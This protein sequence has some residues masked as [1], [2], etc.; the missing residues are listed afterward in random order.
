VNNGEQTTIPGADPVTRFWTDMM[1]R[2]AATGMSAPPASQ[3]MIEQ[4][5][6]AFFDV[7]GKHVDDFM[8]SEQFLSTMKQAMDNALVFRQQFNEFLN[9][10]LEALQ[11]PSSSDVE[12][13]VQIVRSMG[14]RITGRLD[15]LD[16]RLAHLEQ[17]I[18][19]SAPR[20]RKVCA[21]ADDEPSRDREGAV[22]PT[23][24]GPLPYGRGSDKISHTRPKKA[25]IR[26]AKAKAAPR[27]QGKAKSKARRPKRGRG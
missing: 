23:E 3:E 24:T 8:R 11:M 26:A 19:G 22:D 16:S 13:V 18:N 17:A 27:G 20:S 14:Q 15:D 9:K 1:G 10:N 21:K 25:P 7:L 5:R 6:T 2:L 4:M 12:E